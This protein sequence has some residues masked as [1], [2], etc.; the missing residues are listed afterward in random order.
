MIYRT[1]DNDAL[2]AICFQHYAREDQVEQVLAAN[3][4]LAERGPIL[5]AGIRIN[6]P[7]ATPANTQTGLV[8]IWD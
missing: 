6:L 1:Q 4:G 3:P 2:D 8:Q 7:A 5:P